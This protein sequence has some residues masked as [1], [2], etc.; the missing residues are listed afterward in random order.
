MLEEKY[1]FLTCKEENGSLPPLLLVLLEAVS[2]GGLS[3]SA[4]CL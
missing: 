1:Y 3:I 2:I 4:L